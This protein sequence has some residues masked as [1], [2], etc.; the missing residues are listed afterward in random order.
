MKILD[1][2]VNDAVTVVSNDEFPMGRVANPDLPYT[3]TAAQLKTFCSNSP[4]LSA[5]TITNYTETAY[6]VANAGATETI[7]LANGT[8]QLITLTEACTIT[9]PVTTAGKCFTIILTGNFVPTWAAGSG[10]T[11]KWEGGSA[12]A[13]TASA[14]KYDI[15][16]FVAVD[17]TNT[18]GIDGGR[19]L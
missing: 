2:A 14:G 1:N 15:Y 6:V 13:R 19:N 18:L 12:P 9:L 7:D 4:T 11:L 8:L 17:S 10:R 3:A 5:P 16:C